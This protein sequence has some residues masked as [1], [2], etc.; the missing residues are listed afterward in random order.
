VVQ[1][2]CK[3]NKPFDPLP[4]DRERTRQARISWPGFPWIATREHTGGA[5]VPED[6]YY[7][8]ELH[9]SHVDAWIKSLPGPPKPP[10]YAEQV[11]NWSGQIW[12]LEHGPCQDEARRQER[13]EKL[14]GRIKNI[15][16][17]CNDGS[18][19]ANKA[20][21]YADNEWK[22]NTNISRKEMIWQVMEEAG[23]SREYPY[24][25]IRKWIQKYDP[26]YE[27]GK[28][29]RKGTPKTS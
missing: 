4:G 10:P 26:R 17:D 15:P 28:R 16:L 12:A 21:S 22:Q 24:D 29:G 6:N 1:E 25:T 13:I 19:D 3:S 23:L 27:S 14:Q 18:A 20:V 11:S 7:F 5:I 9:D 8:D 2:V